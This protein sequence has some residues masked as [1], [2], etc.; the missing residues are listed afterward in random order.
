LRERADLVQLT[1]QP[2]A[3]VAVLDGGMPA[4]RRALRCESLCLMAGPVA[5]AETSAR[6]FCTTAKAIMA[7]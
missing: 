1:E 4:G 7:R 6:L 2:S 3:K 5:T